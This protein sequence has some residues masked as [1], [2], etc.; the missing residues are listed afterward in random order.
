MLPRPLL[1]LAFGCVFSIFLVPVSVAQTARAS[2][3]GSPESRDVRSWLMR[4]HSAA[5]KRNFQGTFIVSGGGAVSSAR[6][7][8]Y[9]EAS[10]QF[11]RIESMDGEARHVFRHNEVVHTLWPQSRVALVEQRALM[12]SFPG[13]LSGGCAYC[14]TI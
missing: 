3:D 13:L 5:S 14:T 8:H 7:A 10:S 1:A 4:I 6:I 9:C 12:S 11:E 2:A